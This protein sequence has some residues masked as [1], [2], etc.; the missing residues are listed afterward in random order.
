M[1]D[2]LGLKQTKFGEIISPIDV[3]GDPLQGQVEVNGISVGTNNLDLHSILSAIP[4]AQNQ[5]PL[6]IQLTYLTS[7]KAG[8]DG[9]YMPQPMDETHAGDIYTNYQLNK[10]VF[11]GLNKLGTLLAMI[12]GVRALRQ[13]DRGILGVHSASVYDRELDRTHILIGRSRAGKSSLSF[14]LEAD[15]SSRFELLADDW[16]EI[17]LNSGQVNPIS[18]VFSGANPNDDRYRPI[19]N[20]FGKQ[21]YTKP[22]VPI[23]SRVG[24]VILIG[25]SQEE[26]QN[27]ALFNSV[28]LQIP[29]VGNKDGRH[30]SI[31]EL[32]KGTA[33]SHIVALIAHKVQHLNSAFSSLVSSQGTINLIN[34]RS[35][36]LEQLKNNLIMTL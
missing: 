19:F 9:V 27:S 10:F 14:A 18:A 22:N 25:K 24:S 26:L 33:E 12:Y 5:D 17:D 30:E 28:E 13:I 34:D 11:V 15:Q 35:L 2:E 29:F 20:S 3:E 7:N 1:I 4:N 8:I 16:N 23:S 31:H 32:T 6:G 36:S 21:F